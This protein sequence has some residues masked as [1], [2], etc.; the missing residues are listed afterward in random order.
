[1]TAPFSKEQKRQII[2]LIQDFFQGERDEQIGIIAAQG[3]LDFIDQEIGPYY[4]NQ[5]IRDARRLVQGQMESIDTE[6]YIMEKP[7]APA[8]SE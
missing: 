5:A 8:A 3:L 7:V 4:Y 1:V 2:R 6:L